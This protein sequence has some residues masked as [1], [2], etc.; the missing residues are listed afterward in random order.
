MA[1][2][3]KFKRT[4]QQDGMPSRIFDDVIELA[5]TLFRNRKEAAADQLQSL[6]EATKD[7]AAAMT[8]IPTLQKQV[9]L[10]SENMGHFADYVYNTTIK[11]MV[12]DATVFA[13]QRP[14]ITI[15]VAAVAGLAATRMMSSSSSPSQP[16]MGGRKKSAGRPGAE[17]RTMNGTT[18]AQT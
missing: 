10:A 12:K 13:R 2:S 6:S 16:S 5:S 1:K 11:S 14:L 7:Y 3:K 17:R 15:G 8:D 9:Q 18:H 4:N